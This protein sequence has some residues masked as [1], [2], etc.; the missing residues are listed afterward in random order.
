MKKLAILNTSILTVDGLFNLKTIS[1]EEAKRVIDSYGP[2]N[3]IS[4][5]EHQSTADVLSTLLKTDIKVNRIMFEQEPGQEALCFKLNGRPEEG[6][7]LTAEEIESIGYE[8]K[9]LELI[10]DKGEISDGYH[11]FNELY[12][13]R[14]TLFAVICNQNKE[15]AWKSLKH[16]D[17]SMFD[18]FFI[19]GIDTPAGQYTYHY[20]IKHWKKFNV[21]EIL[22]APKYDGHKPD[23]V[24]RLYG[25]HN[26]N[27]R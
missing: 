19:V 20:H 9:L 27:E 14:M 18:D 7:I 26:F 17:G 24:D 1:L 23:D 4:A 16:E 6:K 2:E 21:K 8:F 12:F 22:K 25:I 15:L 5:V 10:E 3:I 13:H 11:T